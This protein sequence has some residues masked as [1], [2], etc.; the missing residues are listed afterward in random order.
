MENRE[1]KYTAIATATGGRNGFVKSSDGI[2]D[3][4]V[5]KPVEFGG[6]GGSYTN[7]EQLFAAGWSACFDSALGL[8]A[9]MRKVEIKS[10]TTAEIT[11]GTLADGTIGLSA[12]L[13]VKIDGVER[14]VAERLLD[15]AH[16]VCPYSK[17]TRNNIEVELILED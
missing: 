14:A 2:L 10:R 4:K 3:L 5:S 12:V 7:P 15:A 11:L 17:A 13:K 9:G 8:V 6:D 16:R 1:R